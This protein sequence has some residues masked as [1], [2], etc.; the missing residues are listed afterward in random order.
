MKTKNIIA[1]VAASAPLI[2]MPSAKAGELSAIASLA[3]EATLC[4]SAGSPPTECTP[5]LKKYFSI[6]FSKPWKTIA[7]RKSFLKLCPDVTDSKAGKIAAESLMSEA[8]DDGPEKTAKEAPDEPK[9]GEADVDERLPEDAKATIGSELPPRE[10]IQAALDTLKPAW[11]LQVKQSVA[12]RTVLESCIAMRGAVEAGNCE[13]EQADFDAKRVPA[14][15]LRNE[16]AR[17]ESM[18]VNAT[19]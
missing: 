11:S 19:R 13:L 16:I 4:L 15:T 3:C 14:I 7:A 9:A 12:A 18:L 17:L 2:F 5:S 1:A 10:Q 8:S 6:V